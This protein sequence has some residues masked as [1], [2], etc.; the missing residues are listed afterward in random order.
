MNDAKQRVEEELKQVEERRVRLIQFILWNQKFKELPDEQ[1]FLLKQQEMV[2]FTY[3][4][5]LRR[6]LAIWKD[7]TEKE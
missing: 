5:I 7:D 2:M 6:R 3:V 4:E 1:Q